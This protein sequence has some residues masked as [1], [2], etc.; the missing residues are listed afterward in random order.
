MDAAFDVCFGGADESPAC[1]ADV[2][3]ELFCLGW[4]TAPRLWSVETSFEILA[5]V[6]GRLLVPPLLVD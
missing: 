4:S 3:F 2:T 1:S 5:G 6:W